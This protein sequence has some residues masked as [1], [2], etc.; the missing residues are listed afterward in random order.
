MQDPTDLT[1]NKSRHLKHYNDTGTS[2][3]FPQGVFFPFQ[4]ETQNGLED[5][6][7]QPEKIVEVMKHKDTTTLEDE[8]AG[9]LLALFLLSC[10]CACLPAIV[11]CCAGGRETTFLFGVGR[12][13]GKIYTSQEQA[14]ALPFLCFQA[15]FILI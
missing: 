11:L 14:K 2:N 10:L 5:M 4:S 7:K 8:K 13:A 6:E 15:L 3:P 9:L 1:G 12:Q